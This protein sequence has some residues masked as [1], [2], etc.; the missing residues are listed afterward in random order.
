MQEKHGADQGDDR[1]FFNKPVPQIGDGVLDQNGPVVDGDHFHAFRESGLQFVEPRLD[2]AHDLVD[3]FARAHHDDAADDLP[4]A[5]QLG[6]SAANFR[7]ELDGRDVLNGDRSPG[8]IH[9]ERDLPHVVEPLDVALPAH[10]ELG[11]R[12][13]ED[14]PPHVRIAPPDGVAD[15]GQRDVVGA[16]PVRVHGDLVL[17][18]EPADAGHLG[19]SPHRGEF[20]LE[21]PVLERP[22]FRE[23]LVLRA[24]R[25]HVR[26]AD[27]ARIGAQ[28]RVDSFR[29]PAAD[30]VEVLEDPAPGPVEVG[31]VLE[32][33]IDER[34]PEETSIRAPRWRKAPRASGW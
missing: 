13:L 6:E 7:P 24:E 29:Q 5:V 11:L 25:V 8:S 22:Q 23:I 18:D 33:H 28:R 15:A 34:D 16:Q 1:H 21:E 3:V 20:E 30:V 27:A 2:P 31:T 9:P 4:L 32:D 26:P 14:P 17:P 10:H 12:G 19:D